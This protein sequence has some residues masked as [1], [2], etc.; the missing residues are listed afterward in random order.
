MRLVFVT[1]TLDPEH[2][3]LAQTLDLV[4]ALAARVD[5]LVVLCAGGRFGTEP[6]RER[7]RA[8]LRRRHER[9]EGTSHS[10]RASRPTS[11]GTRPD[12]VLVHMVPT[13]P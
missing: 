13:S 10:E 7:R 5:E 8:H 2:G 9:G 3:S 4:A 1:Q 12:A 6:C 11:R